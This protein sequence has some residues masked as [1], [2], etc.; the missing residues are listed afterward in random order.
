MKTPNDPT[1]DAAKL[2]D[3]EVLDRPVRRQFPADYK[4]RILAECDAAPA[5][6]VGRILRREGLYSSHL[7]D[8]RA[9]RERGTQAALAPKQRGAE[10]RAD[11][12]ARP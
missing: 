9:A 4:R 11:E 1:P 12:R 2:A 5:G 7:R 8:W 10:G 6:S 3:P